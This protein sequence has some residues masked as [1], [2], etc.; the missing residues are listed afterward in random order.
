[1]TTLRQ[2]L[3][4]GLTVCSLGV[5]HFAAQA[6]E[7]PAAAARGQARF[8]EGRAR[9]QA[10]LHEQLKLSAEQEPAWNTYVAAIAPAA[11][12]PD[13]RAA[14]AHLSAPEKMENG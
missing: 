2:H 3:M 5:A 9:H 10:K 12:P 6:Q 8:A 14:L 4:I 1:M 7:A 11:A 13:E